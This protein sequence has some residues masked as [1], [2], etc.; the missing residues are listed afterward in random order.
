MV[1]QY[2]LATDDDALNDPGRKGAGTFRIHPA[3]IAAPGCQE[4]SYCCH[5]KELE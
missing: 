5:C 1:I 3:L 4:R 2:R